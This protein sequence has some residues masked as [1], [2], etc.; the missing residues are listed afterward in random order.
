MDISVIIIN[1]KSERFLE[2]CIASLELALRDISY[3]IIIVNNDS[4][5][6]ED[7]LKPKTQNLRILNRKA[8]DGFAKACN[9]GAK[10]SN[11]KF[12]FFLNPDTKVHPENISALFSTLS[13]EGTGVSAPRLILPNGK[14]QPW[15]NGRAI[16]FWTL[17]GNNLGLA[18]NKNASL[19][20][21]SHETD[22]VS[23]AALAI[24][25]KL[26]AMHNG[27]DE[28][29]FMYFEDIDLCR[30][31]KMSGYKILSLPQIEVLHI[32]GQS[33]NETQ[34]QKLHYYQSQDYYFKKHFGFATSKAVS[35]MRS[36]SF[37]LERFID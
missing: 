5:I 3:E 35:T 1:Y 30:R 9:A 37:L 18:K 4:V 22:W 7:I 21:Q 23:G 24:P 20:D 28:N 13:E 15:S 31:V 19:T 25:K 36:L 16:T 17:L 33:Y 8:N 32:G 11:G 34:K 27:F 10:I 2:E 29:F 6:L 26:F 14:P 12:L